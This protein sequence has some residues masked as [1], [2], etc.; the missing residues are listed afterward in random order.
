MDE[1]L[2]LTLCI[3]FKIK[4]VCIFNADS[5]LLMNMHKFNEKQMFFHAVPQFEKEKYELH[6]Y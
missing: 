6:L 2:L 3:S 4:H 5:K 1:L